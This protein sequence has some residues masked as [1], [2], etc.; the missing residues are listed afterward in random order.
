MSVQKLVS[1]SETKSADTAIDGG[2]GKSSAF[3]QIVIRKYLS[4]RQSIIL[5]YKLW[6]QG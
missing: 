3:R 1:V 5:T 6:R 2:K 4:S